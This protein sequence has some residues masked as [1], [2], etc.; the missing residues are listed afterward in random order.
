MLVAVVTQCLFN[1]SLPLSRLV[2][3]FTADRSLQIVQGFFGSFIF[4][5]PKMG[6]GASKTGSCAP[7]QVP[8]A[9]KHFKGQ[10]IFFKIQMIHAA[11]R[12]L[13]LS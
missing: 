8:C 3:H 6:C 5:E 12:N 1:S 9:G 4:L 11:H 10:K 13:S 7:V 2:V